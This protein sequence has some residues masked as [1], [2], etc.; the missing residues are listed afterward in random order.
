MINT[1]KQWLYDSAGNGRIFEAGEQIPKGWT[2]GSAQSEPI[3]DDD[4]LS[5]PE[6]AEEKRL[7]EMKKPE[8]ID[9]AKKM[10]LEVSGNMRK[11]DILEAVNDHMEG[12]GGT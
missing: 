6:P 10:G 7:S 3:L 11:V 9:A 12:F 2:D 5:D 8:L 4:F 1:H